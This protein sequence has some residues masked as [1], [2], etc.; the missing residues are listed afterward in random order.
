MPG[1]RELPSGRLVFFFSDV[2]G[3]TRLLTD[4]GGRYA[5]L[6]GE[7]QR[8]MRAAFEAHGGTEISTEG[9]S[10]FAVF[11]S[12]LDAVAAAADAQRS[13]AAFDWPP[14]HA[15][16]VRIG[17]HVGQ[18]IVAGDNYV[19]IDINRA[20]RISN[21][22]NGGQVVLSDEMADSVAGN[23]AGRP[24]AAGSWPAPAQGHRRRAALAARDRRQRSAICSPPDARGTPVE[25]AQPG[26]LTHRSRGRVGRAA[27]ADRRQPARDDH[28]CRRDRK[29]PAG[30][31]G[32][33]R[34]A[35]GLSRTA[36][37]TSISHRSTGS[38]PWLRS[39][40]R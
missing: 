33:A 13:L 1:A 26:D 2:E 23:A 22:A 37:S 5:P 17:L 31:R 28:R 10:F 11:R 8:L 24:A 3:S 12:A 4:L 36:S 6:L 9:D 30:R 39:W 35:S 32:C 29:E 7:H 15:F 21:A 19:G 14:G 25:S 16:R 27:A 34:H 18:A 40:R 20:A 38:R